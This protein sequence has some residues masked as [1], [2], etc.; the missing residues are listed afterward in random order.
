MEPTTRK[1]V[2]HKSSQFTGWTCTVCEWAQPI[3]RLV[4]SG[5]I[6]QGILRLT[7][8]ITSALNTHASCLPLHL[9]VNFKLHYFP[10]SKTCP[11][12]GHCIRVKSTRRTLSAGIEKPH[13]GSRIGQFSVL[14]SVYKSFLASGLN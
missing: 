4:K 1:L 5:A 10:A 11:H 3:P 6:C 7:S 12:F 14:W 8:P 2:F 13:D 9:R